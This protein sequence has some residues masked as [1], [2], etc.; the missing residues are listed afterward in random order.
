MKQV[1][2]K[3]LTLTN[4]ELDAIDYSKYNLALSINDEYKN[5]FLERSGKEHYRLL[6]FI[7]TLFN[8][9]KI[10]DIGTNRGYSAIALSYN[11]NNKVISYDIQRYNTIEFLE[12]QEVLKNI[13]FEIGNCLDFEDLHEYSLILLDTAH[14]GVFEKL[15]IEKLENIKWSGIL[16]MDDV[17]YF[18]ALKAMWDSFNIDKYDITHLGHISGTGM[19]IFNGEEE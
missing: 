16:L 18:P 5:Y 9:L 11:K 14:D 6:S 19:L 4:H 3:I 2:D 12:S 17:I 13:R 15:V 8:N 7:S 1:I 10:L